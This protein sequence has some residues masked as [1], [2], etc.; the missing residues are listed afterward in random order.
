[1]CALNLCQT[2]YGQE[3]SSLDSLLQNISKL[4][5]D[6]VK[7]LKYLDIRETVKSNDIELDRVVLNQIIQVCFKRIS[8]KKEESKAFFLKKNYTF[9]E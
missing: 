5:D 6:S 1:M 4:E 2:V 7:I 9:P 3:N 8:S